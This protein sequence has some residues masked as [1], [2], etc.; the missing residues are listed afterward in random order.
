VAEDFTKSM[1]D[2][3]EPLTA[4]A[5]RHAQGLGCPPVSGTEQVP[6]LQRGQRAATVVDGPDVRGVMVP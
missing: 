1:E 3:T 2:P 6:L 4:A 5:M